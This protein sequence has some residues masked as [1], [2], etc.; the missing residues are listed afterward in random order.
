MGRCPGWD[1]QPVDA[2]G[3]DNEAPVGGVRE[4]V[5]YG[6]RRL[7]S[8]RAPP[9]PATHRFPLA[10]NVGSRGCPHRLLLAMQPAQASNTKMSRRGRLLR[11]AM[12]QVGRRG[13]RGPLLGHRRIGRF[14]AA[15]SQRRGSDKRWCNQL[16]CWGRCRILRLRI[17]VAD[18]VRRLV[19]A[20]TSSSPTLINRDCPT[21]FGGF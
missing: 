2:S 6:R 20:W 17:G 8:S 9:S 15:S 12:E 11:A 5:E 10:V 4:G 13:Q 14:P 3:Q 19:L 16:R 7:A 1:W 18:G 21:P